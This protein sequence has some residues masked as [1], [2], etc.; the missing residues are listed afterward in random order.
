MSSYAN[1]T[2]PVLKKFRSGGFVGHGAARQAAAELL[3]KMNTRGSLDGPIKALSGGNQQKVLLARVIAQNADLVLLDEPTKGVDI[4]AKA[5]IYRII[6]Q[7]ADKGCCV[8]VVSSEEEELLDVADN[9]T[10]FRHGK[11]DGVIVPAKELKPADLR[12]AAWEHA[13]P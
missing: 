4:G 7:L 3:G 13:E 10:V 5:D 11:C 2:L 12:K 8:I 1:A 6:H 9:I